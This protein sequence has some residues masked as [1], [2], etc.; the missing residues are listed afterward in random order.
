MILGDGAGREEL[1]ELARQL[2]VAEEISLPGFVANPFAYLSR[3]A[4]FV[5][6]SAWEGFGNVVVEALACG[7]PVVSTDCESGPAEILDHGTHGC[8]VP[9]GDDEAMARAILSAIESPGDPTRRKARSAEFTVDRS[10]D[11]YLALFFEASLC[12]D[13][14]I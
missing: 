12:K 1:M 3:A 9:V 2:G 4:V 10:V 7:P 14:E 6:S 13:R 5:L 8:L 11:R